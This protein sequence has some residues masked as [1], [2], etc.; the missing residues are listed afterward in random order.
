MAHAFVLIDDAYKEYRLRWV[1]GTP[2]LSL[3]NFDKSV[4]AFNVYT[5]EERLYYFDSSLQ[6]EQTTLSML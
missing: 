3:S 1:L 2:T 5:V 6:M 4:V